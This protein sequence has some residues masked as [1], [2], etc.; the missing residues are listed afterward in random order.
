MG[1]HTLLYYCYLFSEEETEKGLTQHTQHDEKA[2]KFQLLIF[3]STEHKQEF[4]LVLA[5]CVGEKRFSLTHSSLLLQGTNALALSRDMSKPSRYS[6]RVPT[7]GGGGGGNNNNDKGL[8][9]A[10][11]VR[12]EKPLSYE[13]PCHRCNKLGHK[14]KDCSKPRICA[15]CGQNGHVE[16]DCAHNNNNNN[17]NRNNNGAV[18]RKK[19]H[20][21]NYRGSVCK[22]CGQRGGHSSSKC[23][24]VA[25]CKICTENHETR[26]CPRNLG[27]TVSKKRREIEEQ[28]SFVAQRK[29]MM[30][31]EEIGAGRRADGDE[32]DANRRKPRKK[33]KLVRV[34]KKERRT[35]P[36]KTKKTKRSSRWTT[37]ARLSSITPRPRTTTDRTLRIFF[38]SPPIEKSKSK[39]ALVQ[40]VLIDR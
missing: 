27:G 31:E 25:R 38:C 39:I 12:M 2:K 32:E 36:R 4:F 18:P 17:N 33:V 40:R 21:Q 20:G 5:C 29:A 3:E 23:P 9:I 35:T 22:R 37:R 8:Q 7:G 11:G 28:R 6:N 19:K 16:R 10:T 24:N 14:A 30:M 26:E 15:K 13:G 34:K 1:H